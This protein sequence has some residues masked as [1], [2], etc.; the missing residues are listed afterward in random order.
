MDPTPLHDLAHARVSRRGALRGVALGAAGLGAVG[1]GIATFAGRAS[2]DITL[3]KL[4]QQPTPA[5]A[6]LLG[7][8]TSLERALTA[9][10][11]AA[12]ATGLASA[13][14]SALLTTFGINHDQHATAYAALAGK[15]A[16]ATPN[17]QLTTELTTA[18]AAA[19][20]TAALMT[21]L[22]TA[23]EAMIATTAKAL[24][25]LEGTLG[26]ERAASVLAATSRQSVVLAQQVGAAADT[27]LPKFET[28]AAAYSS[29]SYPVE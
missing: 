13:D 4:T 18:V 19:K 25:E 3:P 22:R 24:G 5:D 1:A 29:A 11:T 8:L 9:A 6:S 23:E 26:S 12:V 7:F 2:A 10:Y 16:N 14:A 21:V 15:S 20:N 17:P 27:Y 28:V